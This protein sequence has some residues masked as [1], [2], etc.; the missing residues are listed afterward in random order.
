[1][2]VLDV[3]IRPFGPRFSQIC[4]DERSVQ[5]LIGQQWCCTRRE[6]A[7]RLDRGVAVPYG[8]CEASGDAERG[9]G[10]RRDG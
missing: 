7:D 3:Y 8:R 10:S 4:F 6:Q 2:D 1:M 5:L 9:M